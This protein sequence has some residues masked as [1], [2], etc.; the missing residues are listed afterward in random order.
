MWVIENARINSASVSSCVLHWL[1]QGK[2]GCTAVRKCVY[3]RLGSVY[4]ILHVDGVLAL[5]LALFLV[6]LLEYPFFAD[7][8]AA[9]Y[10]K[11]HS[12]ECNG[13]NGPCW[14][15]NGK[16]NVSIGWKTICVLSPQGSESMRFS[17]FC[18]QVA[19]PLGSCFQTMRFSGLYFHDPMFKINIIFSGSCSQVPMYP[20]LNVHYFLCSQSTRFLDLRILFLSS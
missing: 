6:L 14:H 4:H 2:A 17:G 1:K 10:D 13:H 18:S 9:G 8:E 20:A 5:V 7:A 16:K 11:N 12:H 15:C 3:L 19:M